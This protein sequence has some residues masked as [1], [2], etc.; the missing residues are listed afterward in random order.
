[1]KFI[2]IR[3]YETIPK[4]TIIRPQI[5]TVKKEPLRIATV[6]ATP[7]CYKITKTFHQ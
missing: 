2:I 3:K 5:L 6:H 4:E 7:R 1:M